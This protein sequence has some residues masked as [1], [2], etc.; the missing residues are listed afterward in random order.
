M[1]NY[2]SRLDGIGVKF[3]GLDDGWNDFYSYWI[4]ESKT[5]DT[6]E[7]FCFIV[8]ECDVPFAEHESVA[9]MQKW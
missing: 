5:D 2:D 4:Q 8:S 6:C 1:Q 3:T 9:S 7:D